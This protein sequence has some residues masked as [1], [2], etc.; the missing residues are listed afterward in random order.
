MKKG[1]FRN[2]RNF[3]VN[4]DIDSGESIEEYLN[5]TL[6]QGMAIDT[7]MKNLYYTE[8]KDGVR[9]EYDHRSDRF[10]MALESIEM[11]NFESVRTSGH[12]IETELKEGKYV[13]A[14]QKEVEKD[15]DDNKTLGQ[16]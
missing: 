8:K 7:P 11:A 10:E 9:P 6:A 14:L 1:N 15:V 3:I 12:G 2:K 4:A 5:R 16:S 13:K